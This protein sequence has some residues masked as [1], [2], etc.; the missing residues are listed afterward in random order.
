MANYNLIKI[1]PAVYALY[2]IMSV[3]CRRSNMDLSNL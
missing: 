2:Q 3:E 1:V